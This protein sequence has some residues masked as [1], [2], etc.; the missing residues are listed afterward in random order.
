[1]PYIKRDDKSKFHNYAAGLFLLPAKMTPGELNWAIT[2][3][4]QEYV[5]HSH[6]GA[7]C[8][9][10]INDIMGALEGAKQEFYRRVAAPYE[11]IKAKENGDVYEE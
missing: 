2:M 9:A 8:Y 6:Q 10:T 5:K 7:I 4:I 11:D 1:M 3:L